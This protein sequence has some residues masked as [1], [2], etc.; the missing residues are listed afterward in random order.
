MAFNSANQPGG[1]V[2]CDDDT[3]ID[4]SIFA[5]NSVVADGGRDAA[6]L[7]CA[8]IHSLGYN[9]YQRKSCTLAPALASDLQADP[10]LGTLV[11]AGGGLPIAIL[12]PGSPAVDSGAPGDDDG[13]GGH[14]TSSDQRGMARSNGCDRGAYEQRWTFVLNSTADAPDANIGNGVCLSTLGGC[15]LRAALQEAAA[16]DEPAVIRVTPGTYD[17]NIPGRDEDDGAT[18]DLDIAA[19]DGA[20]R[21]LVGSGPDQS[22]I[23]AHSGDRV[24]GTSNNS[25]KQA[26]IGLFGLRIGG[27]TAVDTAAS[28]SGKGGGMLLI[29]D[30]HTTIDNDWF[31]GNSAD[32]EGG[33][34]YLTSDGSTVRITRSAFTR[35]AAGGDGGG[36]ELAQGDP[37]VVR[38]SLFADNTAAGFGGGLAL[39]NSGDVEVAYTTFTGNHTDR[40]SGGGIVADRNTVLSAIL[41]SGNTDAGGAGISSPDC[42]ISGSGAAISRGYNVIANAPGCLLSGDLTGNLIGVAAPMSR[43]TVLGRTMPWSAPQPSNPAVDHA[44]LCLLGNGLVE[45]FDQFGVERPGEDG[46]ADNCTS[47]AI[48]GTSDLIYADGLDPDYPGL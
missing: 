33:G 11:D 21:V 4:N 22:I 46:D 2:L 48:E 10:L 27:G 45:V 30:G 37:L 23:R 40:S 39:S 16:S 43:V 15:T 42:A 24:F 29:T 35:N 1:G 6:D 25:A 47:G 8:S 13:Q 36:A 38:D 5:Y 19:V 20:A 18:G 41:S 34:L 32:A 44:P 14:C 31:D 26:P 7:S 28:F 9:T 12:L 17:V 3:T